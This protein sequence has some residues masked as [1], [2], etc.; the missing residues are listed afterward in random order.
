[1]RRLALIWIASAAC[2]A[3]PP[4]LAKGSVY[5]SLMG[6]PFRTNAAGEHP[7][8]QWLKLADGNGD[9]S[10]SRLELRSDA[11]AFCQALDTTGDKVIDADDM[12]E[13]EQMAPGRTRAAGGVTAAVSSSR[14]TPTSGRSGGTGS[15]C[16]RHQQRHLGHANPSRSGPGGELRQRA[17]AVAMADLNS[18][19]G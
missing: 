10:I 13:Y 18:T 15:G 5:M 1:M 3:A 6:E 19:G 16:T 12:A 2:I 9:G 7:F 11:E 4:A 17:L 14:T 8:D